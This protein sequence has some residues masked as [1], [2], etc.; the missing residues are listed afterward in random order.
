MPLP[1]HPLKQPA[2]EPRPRLGRA[3]A[4]WAAGLRYEDLPPAAVAQIKR[5]LLDTLAVAW[6]GTGATGIEAVCALA[7]RIRV[8]I[9]PAQP[10]KFAPATVTVRTRAGA[11]LIATAT[12]LPGTPSHPMTDAQ[13]R[14]K[15]MACFRSGARPLAAATAERLM[16]Q[17]DR[18][19]ALA[20]MRDF[21]TT[22]EKGTP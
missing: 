1:M 5:L 2:N 12:E 13:L 22:V 14:N 19:E 7:Q 4:Q 15:A 3:L 8:E 6:A 18:V 20:D 9:D 21:W 16:A 10:G 17:I 11:E